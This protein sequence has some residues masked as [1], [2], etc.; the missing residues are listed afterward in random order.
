MVA[1]TYTV[2]I[3]CRHCSEI[4]LICPHNNY[5][6]VIIPIL[7]ISKLSHEYSF[8][9]ITFHPFTSPTQPQ[10]SP[11]FPRP[12]LMGTMEAKCKYAHTCTHAHIYRHTLTHA[13]TRTGTQK[14][15]GWGRPG[16]LQATQMVG[17]KGR[18]M[19]TNVR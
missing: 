1:S 10:D 8:C 6:V 7:H 19:Q 9:S 16:L 13:C 2:L 18:V 3:M 12:I 17:G 11:P 5:E 4:H 15:L 14:G